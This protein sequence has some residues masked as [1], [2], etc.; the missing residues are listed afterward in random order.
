MASLPLSAA[1]A[2]TLALAVVDPAHAHA[3]ARAVA[4]PAKCLEGKKDSRGNSSVDGGEISWEDESHYDDAR[5]HS[6]KAWRA[7]GLDRVTFPEDDNSRIADLEWSDVNKT[8]GKWQN[9]GGAWTGLPGTDM[10]RLNDAYLARG[11]SLGTDEWRRRVAAHELGH[12]LGFCHK[13]VDWYSTLM[14]PKIR[15]TPEDGKPTAR[16]RTNYHKLWG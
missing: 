5:K 7:G 3:Q 10:I 11:K 9:I 14:D 16:D 12:A 15:N 6:H 4:A 8:S 2:T 13:S 1:L